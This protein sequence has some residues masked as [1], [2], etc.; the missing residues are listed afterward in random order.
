MIILRAILKRKLSVEFI[1]IKSWPF[2][3]LGLLQQISLIFCILGIIVGSILVFTVNIYEKKYSELRLIEQNERV[4]SFLSAGSLDA[5]ISEDRPVLETLVDQVLSTDPDI[6]KIILHNEE[7]KILVEK[8]NSKNQSVQESISFSQDVI[9]NGE[10]FG[11]IE[12]HWETTSFSNQITEQTKPFLILT[13]VLVLVLTLI[14]FVSIIYYIIKPI[15]K[16]NRKLLQLSDNSQITPISLGQNTAIEFENLAESVNSLRQSQ[17]HREQ[18]LADLEVAKDKAETS[19]EAKNKFLA[20]MSHE[21]R[22]PINGIIGMAD[23]LK[24][25]RI[26]A[27]QE[28]YLDVIINSS[29]NLMTIVDDIL[30]FS[31]IEKNKFNL[32]IDSFS[33]HGLLDHLRN[34][35]SVEAKNKGIYFTTINNISD[36]IELI[37]DEIHLKQVLINLLSNAFKFTNKGNVSL[38]FEIKNLST[39]KVEVNFHVKDTGIG[40]SENNQKEI[41]KEFKQIDDGFDRCYMGLGLGLSLSQNIVRK[42]G[43]LI[44]VKS[45]EGEGSCFSFAITP[46]KKQETT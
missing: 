7:G 19:N 12:L 13:A 18:I 43:G 2:P 4:L 6:S 8:E 39:N 38:E 46:R 35:F 40:I 26:N 29:E 25:G 42:M 37:G 17:N 45:R 16:I 23:M 9:L 11:S 15:S 10:T 14:F 3:Q 21:I 32:S 28:R 31:R 1:M 36:D 44:T 33:L 34:E 5:I 41:F 24:E 30:D 27:E 20:V 22:T